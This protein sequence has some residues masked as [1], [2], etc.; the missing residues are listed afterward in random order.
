MNE[1]ILSSDLRST[2]SGLYKRLRKQLSAAEALSMT[3]FETIGLL[4]KQEPLLPSEL[5]VLT[6]IKTQSMSQILKNL[7]QYEIIV[8]TPSETDGRK[9][10]ISLTPTGRTMIEQT[11]YEH[12]EWLNNVIRNVLTEE[13]RELLSNALPVLNKIAEAQ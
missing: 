8:R 10:Y 4:Y 7:E 11:L 13:E 9:V 3:T 1:S 6:K 2:V 12:D 5:A